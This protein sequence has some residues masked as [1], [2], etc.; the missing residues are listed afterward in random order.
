M[1]GSKG[2]ILAVKSKIQWLKKGDMNTKFYHSV[3]KAKRNMNR[4]F[5]IKDKMGQQQTELDGIVKAFI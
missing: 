4:V 5:R 2:P 3:L 1:Q